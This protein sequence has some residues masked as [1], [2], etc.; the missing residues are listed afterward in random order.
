MIIT[1]IT[2]YQGNNDVINTFI[3]SIEELADI[4]NQH[5]LYEII[6]HYYKC[7]LVSSGGNINQVSSS[8]KTK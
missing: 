3:T 6:H 4:Q 5:I 8:S 7:K 1:N 2:Y